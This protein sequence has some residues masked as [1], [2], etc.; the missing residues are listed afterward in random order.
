MKSFFARKIVLITTL[1]FIGIL[2]VQMLW[3]KSGYEYT[4][5][6]F[7]DKIGKVLDYVWQ[8]IDPGDTLFNRINTLAQVNPTPEVGDSA[9][10]PI[11]RK[12]LRTR[13][14]RAMR[15]YKID[16]PYQVVL[17]RK[18]ATLYLPNKAVIDQLSP[19]YQVPLLR[20]CRDCGL[21]LGIHFPGMNLFSHVRKMQGLIWVSCGLIALLV[22]CFAF[23]VNSWRK[24]VKLATQ[25]NAFINNMTH[26]FKTP[27]FTISVAAKILQNSPTVAQEERLQACVQRITNASQKLKAH[28]EQILQ[29]ALFN[30]GNL[31]LQPVKTNIHPLIEDTIRNYWFANNTETPTTQYIFD[32]QSANDEVVIDIHH[33][34]NALINLLDNAHKYR[35]E[36]PLK[37]QLKSYHENNQWVLAIQDNGLGIAKADQKRVFEQFYRVNTGNLHN[38]KGFGLGLHYVKQ[39]V[40]AHQGSVWLES[41]LGQG[42]TFFVALPVI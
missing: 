40:E 29:T 5:R 9:Y 4:Q 10:W 22:A 34:T 35:R 15:L 25:K 7:D 14:D 12:M 17:Y 8:A 11:T 41:S 42:S 31:T 38:T 21:Q 20:N 37:I 18:E 32:W 19:A 27:V 13:F 30:E 3:V 6:A 1:L 26:E 24:Q 2:M 33:F 36:V 16:Q 39:V 23:V 28:T